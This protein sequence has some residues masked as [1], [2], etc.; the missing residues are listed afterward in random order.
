M[1]SGLR[2]SPT[3]VPENKPIN[4]RSQSLPLISKIKPEFNRLIPLNVDMNDRIE[5]FHYFSIDFS[6]FKL[7][8]KA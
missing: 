1:Y 5:R 3:A 7:I 6:L 2:Q 8:V 4:T